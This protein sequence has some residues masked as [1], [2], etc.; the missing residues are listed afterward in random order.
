MIFFTDY[1]SAESQ[2]TSVVPGIKFVCQ[3]VF[4]LLS[5][6]GQIPFLRVQVQCLLDHI[7]SLVGS[8]QPFLGQHKLD[9]LDLIATIWEIVIA[10]HHNY[11]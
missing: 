11:S 5:R 9:L 2:F 4:I 6:F 1:T 8:L 3:N 7:P 10:L